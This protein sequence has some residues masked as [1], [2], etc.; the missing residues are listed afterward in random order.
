MSDK[1][2]V[3][4]L[5]GDAVQCMETAKKI[6][7]GGLAIAPAELVEIARAKAQGKWPRI[8]AIYALG[9]VG[10]DEVSPTIRAILAD[11][12]NDEDVRSHAAEALGN[13]RDRG[14]VIL[15]RDILAH[16]PEPALRDSCEY[17]LGELEA[18]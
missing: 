12:E 8:A 7:A 3:Q 1:S 5:S 18:A 2:L 11:S 4:L 10:G 15:L 6:I 17:A 13:L 9:L 14:A 16:A